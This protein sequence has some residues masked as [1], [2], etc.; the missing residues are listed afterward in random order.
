MAD[1]QQIETA[2]GQGDTLASAPPIPHA[3]PQVA[4][5]DNLRME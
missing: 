3:L 1:M 2:V 4:A 5:R